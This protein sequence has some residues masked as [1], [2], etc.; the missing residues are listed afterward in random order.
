MVPGDRSLA[1]IGLGRTN[2]Y[3][4][5]VLSQPY[6]KCMPS[7]T[8][9]YPGHT[10]SRQIEGEIRRRMTIMLSLPCS[11]QGEGSIRWFAWRQVTLHPDDA[12]DAISGM[13]DHLDWTRVG[14]TKGC[15]ASIW[16]GV[17]R[18]SLANSPYSKGK[19]Q[20]RREKRER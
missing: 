19:L 12:G 4:E 15:S 3:I 11:H 2:T 14:L 20:A 10:I 5:M 8:G 17:F 13:Q 9:S 7:G 16:P 18:Q 6:G 1:K